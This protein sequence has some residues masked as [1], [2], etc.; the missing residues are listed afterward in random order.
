M[1]GLINHTAR[2]NQ[3]INTVSRETGISVER[4]LSRSRRAPIVQARQISMWLSRW[5]SEASLQVIA[6]LHG[7][8]N[9]ANVIH[10]CNQIENQRSVDPGFKEFTNRLR[11]IIN[12]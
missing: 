6:H 11:N 3:I 8:T 1:K 4:I 5:N 2:I 12:E 9:H 7:C 10:G